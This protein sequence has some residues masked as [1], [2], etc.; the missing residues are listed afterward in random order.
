MT[1]KE[2][3]LRS[4]WPVVKHSKEVRIDR[5]A[6][7]TL[8]VSIKEQA[9]PAW[10]NDLQLLAENETET[11][12]YYFFV[13]SVQGCFWARK[14]EERW[15]YKK[16]GDWIKGYYAFAYA[17]KEAIQKNKK[18]LNA[19]YLRTI[20]L[21]EFG[22]IFKGENEL[23]ILP[24][25]HEII[26]ENFTILQEKYG[27]LAANL[28]QSAEGDVNALVYKLVETFPTFNDKAQYEV[29]DV[30]LWK[31]AQIFP[32]DIF[33][34]L[35]GRGL[36]K[37]KNLEDL[38]VFADYR[39]PQFLQAEGVLQYNPS[40]LSKIKNEELIPSG[41]R[42]EV[43]MRSNTIYACDLLVQELHKAGRDITNQQ[44]DW[45]IWSLC[46]NRAFVLPHHK[47]AT[48]FY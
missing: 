24:E 38:T 10:N 48:I 37:F 14:G 1:V 2:R 42:E 45:I 33:F 13:D 4:V 28:V 9:I 31:R 7:E 21:K 41:S 40:L 22:G 17:I 39:L 27:G 18:L 6:L 20:S 5:K 23:Q 3:I 16:E 36:G 12:Q 15:R 46:Q 29:Q 30:Y 11:V 43:E 34:A 47:T 44:L 32:N 19:E 26:K 35:Q 8:A 25:R